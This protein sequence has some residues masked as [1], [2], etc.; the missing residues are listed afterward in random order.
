MPEPT[1]L[2]P[3]DGSPASERAI[4]FLGAL[5]KLGEFRVRLI[6][7]QEDE[8]G[9]EGG[10]IAAYLERLKTNVVSATGLHVDWI[11]PVGI[12]HAHIQAEA[13]NPWVSLLVMS[14]HGRS[15]IER[16]RIGSVADK[17]L[18]GAPCPTLLMG[19]DAEPPQ[20]IR[21]ILV[22]LDGSRL[23][24]EAVPVA[25]ALS[26]KL[27]AS[28]RLISVS[29]PPT[30]DYGAAAAAVTPELMEASRKAA[31]GYLE[32]ARGAFDESRVSTS[33]IIGFPATVLLEELASRPVDLVVMTSH[34][35][36]GFVRW[37]LGSVTDRLIRGPVPVLVLH[38][39]HGARLQPLIGPAEAGAPAQE[40]TAGS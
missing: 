13:A 14:T 1:V 15:G 36:H 27:D 6:R 37:A 40:V 9:A 32:Y 33:V 7:V 34:G 16:W 22:P 4:A 39:G 11:R 5:K 20:E 35:R 18:R 24:E 28:V 26:R 8:G 31:E 17:T 3:V 2:V 21:Q 30:Y 10:A 19:P 25:A 23:A 38:P 12:P 29:L